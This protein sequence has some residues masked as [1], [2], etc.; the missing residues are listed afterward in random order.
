M[1]DDRRTLS[2]HRSCLVHSSPGGMARPRCV[3]GKSRC[4]SEFAVTQNLALNSS[5]PGIE[6]R[7]VSLAFGDPRGT[8]LPVLT[9][10][11]FRVAPG[12][13]VALVGPSGSGK[14]TILELIS[15][16]VRPERGE[17]RVEPKIEGSRLAR[18]YQEP[19]L[20]PWRTVASNV[21]LPLEL[22][23]SAV[24][25]GLRVDDALRRAAVSD[26][27]E[28]FP[29]QL[30]GGLASRAALARALVQAPSLLLLDEPFG[31]LDEVTAEEV[32]VTLA[33]IVHATRATVVL[34]THSVEQA[35]FL[36]DRVLVLSRRPGRVVADVAVTHPRP[37]GRA[38]LSV[39]SFATDVATVRRHLRGLG[40]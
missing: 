23:G 36:A 11:S 6:A 10:L 12:E 9:E 22:R 8:S 30:S 21:G 19:D 37:R 16:R 4:K 24:G 25:V 33:E 29:R 7:A 18:V 40:S 34:V 5:A 39:G 3:P 2:N 26:F 15:G 31:S 27:A 35:V 32:M 38:L 14:S 13:V 20:L 28:Y 17:L 1:R